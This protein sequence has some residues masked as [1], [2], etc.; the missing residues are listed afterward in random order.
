MHSSPSFGYPCK[1]SFST[2]QNNYC[3]RPPP[4]RKFNL[5]TTA[6]SKRPSSAPKQIVG[7][8]WNT[9]Y[10]QQHNLAK[11]NTKTGIPLRSNSARPATKTSKPAKNESKIVERAP[12]F[13][14]LFQSPTSP[15]IV[16]DDNHDDI[17]QLWTNVKDVLNLSQS[18]VAYEQELSG[19]R[20]TQ[21]RPIKQNLN[22]PKGSKKTHQNNRVKTSSGIGRPSN[23]NQAFYS[24]TLYSHPSQP[25]PSNNYQYSLLPNRTNF[26][27]KLV[28]DPNP[29]ISYKTPT[30]WNGSRYNSS[31]SAEECKVMESLERIDEKLKAHYGLPR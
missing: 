28:I 2:K 25:I 21:N 13:Q 4:K 6:Q 12:R 5:K 15:G 29:P 9:G 1:T 20:F 23:P 17:D 30:L 27:P 14:T 10:N 18:N 19:Q 11:Q 16:C 24:D 3:P 7:S 26:Q 31:L 22:R 8:K